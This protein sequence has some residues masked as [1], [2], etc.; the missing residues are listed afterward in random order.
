[1]GDATSLVGRSDDPKDAKTELDYSDL[2]TL[3]QS[4][5]SPIDTSNSDT[6]VDSVDQMSESQDEAERE[7]FPRSGISYGTHESDDVELTSL[8]DFPT[9]P[10]GEE[11]FGSADPRGQFEDGLEALTIAGFG[12]VF[13][14]GAFATAVLSFAQ[15]DLAGVK[16]AVV[17]QLQDEGVPKS[18]AD[19][20]WSEMLKGS[21]LLAVEVT[22]GKVREEAVE[23]LAEQ[24]GG[25]VQGMYDAPRW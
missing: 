24:H 10:A 12:T 19:R 22:P 15:N 17:S 1:V 11:G 5:L 21:A 9:Q 16:T 2:T 4:N 8:T 6:D 7:S 23:Q 20:L 13:G 18:V 14:G 25:K 3:A